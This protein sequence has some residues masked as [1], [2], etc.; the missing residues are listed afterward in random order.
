MPG[1]RFEMYGAYDAAMNDPRPQVVGGGG[2][3]VVT[4]S[5]DPGLTCIQPKTEN[6]GSGRTR[7][8]FIGYFSTSFIL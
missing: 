5:M 3:V 7:L 8:L 2:D 6:G 4:L 1:M